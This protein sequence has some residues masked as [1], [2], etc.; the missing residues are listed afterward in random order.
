MSAPHQ[1]AKPPVIVA[2]HNNDET[3]DAFDIISTEDNSVIA[4]V[5]EFRQ[6]ELIPHQ[7]PGIRA[8]FRAKAESL[9]LAYNLNDALI[10]TVTT[11]GE[12]G[13]LTTGTLANH[14]LRHLMV[15]LSGQDCAELARTTLNSI[16]PA[17]T[18]DNTTLITP[19]PEPNTLANYDIKIEVCPLHL[20]IQAPS[21]HQAIETAI[22]LMTQVTDKKTKGISLPLTE[23]G[24][25]DA[26]ATIYP[27]F[28]PRHYIITHV[29]LLN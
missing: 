15:Q 3:F 28:D 9:A 13:D 26:D 22:A 14:P 7:P 2:S 25:H 19:I 18:P 21:K 20:N 27:S 6:G 11:I 29:E 8:Q 1:P 24:E 23:P 5:G 12:M 10:K 4:V 17:P 16:N